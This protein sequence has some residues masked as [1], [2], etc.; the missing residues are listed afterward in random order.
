MKK[1]FLNLLLILGVIAC[2]ANSASAQTSASEYEVKAAFVY[3]FLKFVDWPTNAFPT[4][5]SPYIIA[6]LGRDPF[7]NP[8]TGGNFLDSAINGKVINE[9]KIIIQRYEGISEVGACHLLFISKLEKD[10][11]KDI[12]ASLD[13]KNILTISETD[14]FCEQGGVINLVRQ[15]GKV[16]FEINL[17]AASRAGL[18]ISSKLLSVAKIVASRQTK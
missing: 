17:Q 16:R 7:D 10:R 14:G 18:K 12:F 8:E 6:V 4:Q 13:E 1:V 11:L 9:R 15:G 2:G 3:N 5:N